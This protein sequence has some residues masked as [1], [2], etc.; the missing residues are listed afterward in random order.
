MRLK[1]RTRKGNHTAPQFIGTAVG[2]ALPANTYREVVVFQNN[3]TATWYFGFSSSITSTTA[4]QLGTAT[5]FILEQHTGPVYGFTTAGA[6]AT[7]SIAELG[8][9]SA[10]VAGSV[11]STDVT[12]G[13]A[14]FVSNLGGGGA[15]GVT[16]P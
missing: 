3:G 9:S 11:Y 12:K 1:S 10:P 8:E 6:T 13:T 2:T 14:S 16:Y 5:T 7:I 4:L 15:R